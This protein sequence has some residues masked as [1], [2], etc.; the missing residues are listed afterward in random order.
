MPDKSRVSLRNKLFASYGLTVLLVGCMLFLAHIA[1]TDAEQALSEVQQ[2]QIQPLTQVNEL[3]AQINQLRGL[4]VGL[5]MQGDFFALSARVESLQQEV[6][7]FDQKLAEFLRHSGTISSERGAGLAASW[8]LLKMSLGKITASATE[9]DLKALQRISVYEAAPRFDAMAQTLSNL[10]ADIEKYAAQEHRQSMVDLEALHM[11]FIFLSGITVLLGLALMWYFSHSLTERI[12]YLNLAFRE[13]ADGDRE[14]SIEVSGDDE[15]SELANSFAEMRDKVDAREVAL[16]NAKD[17]LEERVHKRTHQLRKSNE[18]LRQEIES[19]LKV[20][21]SLRVLSQAVGQSPVSVILTD[22][23]GNIE[24][25]NQAFTDISG[26]SE[27]EVLGQPAKMLRAGETNQ[28]V[29]DEM[30]ET[31]RADLEWHGELCNRKK[32]GSL[33]WEHT[34]IS[35][36]KNDAGKTTHFLAIKQ[37]ITESKKQQEQILRQARYDTLTNLPNRALAMDRLNQAIARAQRE[38]NMAL[39]MFIDLDGFKH[40]NDTLGHDVGDILLI[41]AARRLTNAVREVDTVGR[42]GGDEFLVIMGGLNKR[43]DADL[44][45][46]NL[47]QAFDQPFE[48]AGNELVV[49]PSIGLAIYPD[50]GTDSSLLLRNADLAM[51]QAKEA[52]RNT[53]RFYNQQIHDNLRRR[54]ELEKHLRDAVSNNELSLVYQPIIDIKTGKVSGTEAL[55]RWHSQVLGDISPDQFIPIAEQTGLIVPIGKWVIETACRQAREWHQQGLADL[56]ISV[57]IS[58]RQL[59]GNELYR[60]LKT[61]LSENDMFAG[62]LILEMTEGLLIK[63]P[64]E[65]ARIMGRLK[66]LGVLLAM[67]D[68]GTGYSSL[69]NLKSYPFDILKIDRSFIRDL[70]EDP[71][72]RALVA[73]AIGMGKVLGMTVVAEGV[74]TLEQIEALSALEC[75]RMQGYYSSKPLA[76]E[77]AT[78]WLLRE[79]QRPE[80]KAI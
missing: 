72:D 1:V 43:S 19:R 4:E 54:L 18:K 25:V 45:V 14:R 50:D 42:Q 39:L 63:N 38:R 24:Y 21:S 69:S 36:V 23:D 40:I 44:V 68:F 58:P 17:Q 12:R 55:L 64:M 31:L 41:Q 80:I 56:S 9:M 35:P 48:V 70:V 78:S 46:K 61:A 34:H 65:A 51:Y 59:S 10:V 33:H 6:R 79:Q 37:D 53:Y 13:I 30:W 77:Q 32:S 27:A 15:L 57:N 3:H 20:E 5:A 76:P 60:T 28:A 52:G 22:L 8:R 75:H 11:Q 26:Y 47:L 49:T 2:D 71:D 67:D 62:S 7:K 16:S 73:A 29:F 66:R 74:E